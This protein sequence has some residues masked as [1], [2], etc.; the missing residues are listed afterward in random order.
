MARTRR[1]RPARPLR[2]TRRRAPQPAALEPGGPLTLDDARMLARRR[3]AIRAVRRAATRPAPRTT[4]ADVA[5][6]RRKLTEA[7]E[8]ERER[9]LDEYRATLAILKAR[10]VKA[11][12]RRAV[13]RRRPAVRALTTGA[14]AAVVTAPL[15]ILAE[16][17]SWFEYPKPLFGGGIIPRL[18]T[19]LGVPILNMAKAGDEVRYMLGV[20]ERRE[21]TAR[22]AAGCP[23][24]G[25]W[26]VLLFSGGGND[27]V[28]DPLCLWLRDY[29]PATP[30]AALLDQPRFDTALALVRAGYEDLIAVRDAVSPT[31]HLVF[32]CYDLAI[33]DGRGVCG[34]GPWLKPSFDLR[35]FPTLAARS[36]VVTEMLQQFAQ[37]LA[38]LAALHANLSV[39][40]GQGLL[41][42]QP[43]SWDNELHPKG[44]GFDKHAAL[45]QQTLKAV[46]PTRVF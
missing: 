6:E 28:D 21:L 43:A 1:P 25:P 42:P 45:F 24:G 34:M 37:M 3:P 39:I 14:G 40:D 2:R 36:G 4:L 46:F 11:P 33:P 41:T 32:H 29:T 22:L 38:Q 20:D 35:G 15:Q 12:P 13:R 23:A 18:E 26:D 44:P 5:E 8:R 31:T 27:I 19:R 30:P 16:G 9:R 10:G 17:D 7:R